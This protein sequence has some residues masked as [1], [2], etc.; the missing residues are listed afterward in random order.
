MAKY[1]LST[2]G[3]L[4]VAPDETVLLIETHKWNGMWSVPGGKIEYG[5]SLKAALTREFKEETGLDLYDISWGPVQEAIRSEEFYIDA[6]FI[7]LN[8][9]ARTNSKDV[10]LNDEAQSY[11]WVNA[12]AALSYSLNEPTKELLKFYLAYG[13]SRGLL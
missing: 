1:P 5:E 3:A 9:I 11:S 10:R 8:F 2:V 7:L 13:F 12:E 6:H 4:V